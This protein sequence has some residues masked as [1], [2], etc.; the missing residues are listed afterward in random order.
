MTLSYCSQTVT[1]ELEIKEGVL[2]E[3]DGREVCGPNFPKFS[4]WMSFHV[5]VQT[6]NLTKLSSP[7]PSPP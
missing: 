7:S 6:S 4:H 2:L 1:P 5:S 3:T